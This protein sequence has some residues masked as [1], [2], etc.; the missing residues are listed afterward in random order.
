MFPVFFNEFQF[1]M[2]DQIQYLQIA[3][4]LF[5]VH[6]CICL[7]RFRGIFLARQYKRVSQIDRS[8]DSWLN[9]SAHPGIPTNLMSEK[10]QAGN[11]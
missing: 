10:M 3:D 9:G 7:C 4:F 2:S 11:R 1:V 5:Q 8:D 6:Y